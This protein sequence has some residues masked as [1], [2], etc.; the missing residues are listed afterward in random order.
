MPDL[1]IT[2][3][4]NV[5]GAVSA[6]EKLD[7]TLVKTAATAKAT[8]ASLAKFANTGSVFAAPAI[9]KLTLAEQALNEKN[10]KLKISIQGAIDKLSAVHDSSKVAESGVQIF[11]KGIGELLPS[12]IGPAG[13]GIALAAATVIMQLFADEVHHVDLSSLVKK[14]EDAKKA[15]KDFGDAIDRASQSIVSQAKDIT[16]LRGILIS[17]TGDI[18]NLTIATINQGVAA[19]LFD[20]KNL[21]VQKLLSAEIEQQLKLRKQNAP[22]AGTAFVEGIFSKDKLTREIAKAKAEIQGINDLS[23][24]L[25]NIF[26]SF[27]KVKEIKVKPD[28]ITIEKPSGL[29]PQTGEDL[30]DI[31]LSGLTLTP[32]VFVSPKITFIPNTEQQNKALN[33]FLANIKAMEI[34]AKVSAILADTINSGVSSLADSFAG[35]LTGAQNGFSNLFDGLAKTL[36][37]GLKAIGQ[38][39]VKTYLLIG[40]IEKIKFT[41]PAVGVAVG[42]ALQV[43]GALISSKLA[44]TNA[45]ASGVRNFEG[46]FATVGERGPER[47]FLPTGSSV[48]PNNEVQAFG[49]GRE[50]FIPAVTLSGSDLVISFNRASQQM[51]RNG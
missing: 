19:F 4:G 29:K 39:L 33:D 38:Y 43:L 30:L 27:L 17:T 10:E 28:K 12:L 5:S 20:K 31:P 34:G 1:E 49:G 36:G 26:A 7:K 22:L 45:F 37:N 16:E 25:E 2:A 44:K 11:G 13:L 46:G 35:I 50:I 51:G 14:I 40:V 41:N 6:L 48:Q 15:E 42:F 18:Q 24:G 21:A 8:D 9:N 32:Q 3:T 47:I 23:L